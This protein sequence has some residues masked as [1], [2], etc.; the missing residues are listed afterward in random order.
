MMKST[1]QEHFVQLGRGNDVE[2]L[3]PGR[4]QQWDHSPASNLGTMSRRTTTTAQS[5]HTG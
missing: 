2:G 5:T 3:A 4:P 1:S